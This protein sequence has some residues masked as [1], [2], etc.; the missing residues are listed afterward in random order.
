[1]IFVHF[2]QKMEGR[3]RCTK[4]QKMEGNLV[5]CDVEMLRTKD[6]RLI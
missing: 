5:G 2:E 3:G 6:L 1:M 4:A